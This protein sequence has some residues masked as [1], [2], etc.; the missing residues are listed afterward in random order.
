MLNNI[1]K[2]IG[3][4]NKNSN[5]WIYKNSNRIMKRLIY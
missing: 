5:G 2:Y 4:K 3:K 1:P